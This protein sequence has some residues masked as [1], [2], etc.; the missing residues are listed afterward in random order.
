[1]RAR[2]PSFAPPAVD[3]RDSGR[4]AGAVLGT[5]D[6]REVGFLAAGA[7]A[8][9]GWETRLAVDGLRV[10]FASSPCLADDAAVGAVRR[11]GRPTGLVGDLGRGFLNPPGEVVWAFAASLES[12]EAGAALV[13]FG[14]LDADTALEDLAAAG[15]CSTT[16]LLPFATVFVLDAAVDCRRVDRLVLAIGADTFVGS[17]DMVAFD[18][19]LGAV[20]NFVDAVVFFDTAALDD[21]LAGAGDFADDVG[22]MCFGV[23]GVLGNLATPG[24]RGSGLFAEDAF[25]D[26][27]LAVEIA[28][29]FWV[30]FPF[31]VGLLDGTLIFL[32]G[33]ALSATSGIEE[34]V[35]TGSMGE[36]VSR[37]SVE[38]GLS[39]GL[40][41]DAASAG[42]VTEGISAGSEAK[43]PST[44]SVVGASLRISVAGVS[45]TTS[46]AAASST[47]FVVGTSSTASVAG[48][49]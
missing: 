30:A 34:A 10:T 38:M 25:V 44:I 14:S 3:A 17:F 8:A 39:T 29:G 16:G 49:S 20:D 2:N 18:D 48:A 37:T 5:K 6:W 28:G 21:S 11:E 41:V 1:M 45:S 43:E 27:V 19:S 4:L 40:V 13:T 15:L 33:G 24:D 42:S 12:F 31:V 36:A 22:T 23:V 47:T 9:R 46:V 32:V 35:S 26:P 7:A